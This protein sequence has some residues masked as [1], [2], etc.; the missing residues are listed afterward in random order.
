M[1]TGTTVIMMTVLNGVATFF[2]AYLLLHFLEWLCLISVTSK[3]TE[4]VK[5]QGRQEYL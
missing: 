5:N 2:F 1:L 4:V 3:T